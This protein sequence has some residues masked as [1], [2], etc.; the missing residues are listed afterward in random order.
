MFVFKIS[1]LYIQPVRTV[2]TGKSIN[3]LNE[4]FTLLSSDKNC[5]YSVSR[6]KKIAGFNIRTRINRG[7]IERMFRSFSPMAETRESISSAIHVPAVKKNNTNRCRA[8]LGLIKYKKE[9]DIH[10]TP[11]S[12]NGSNRH[13]LNT[14]VACRTFW[15]L[16]FSSQNSNAGLYYSHLYPV[17]GDKSRH[18]AKTKY[19]NFETNILRKGISGPQ[20]QFPHSCCCERFIYFHDRSPYFA[21]GNIRPILG[22]YV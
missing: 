12:Y 13:T 20:S 19:R 11:D 22:L 1:V 15:F 6:K 7:A 16:V 3:S 10:T 21:G 9:R 2:P 5:S 17:F 18:T 14:I 4:Q 8:A